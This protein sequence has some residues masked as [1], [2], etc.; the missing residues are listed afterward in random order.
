VEERK[1]Y[2]Y[3]PD[4]V[5]DYFGRTSV[6]L[7]HFHTFVGSTAVTQ[8][9]AGGH[10]HSYA[11]ETRVAQNHTHIMNGTSGIEVPV[12]MGHLHQLGGTTTVNNNHSHTYDLYTG[13]PR[14]PRNVKRQGVQATGAADKTGSG[15]TS[16]KR[17]PRFKLRFRSPSSE[18]KQ[19]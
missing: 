6:D 14:A 17:R 16:E 3:T 5:H 4:H 18:Q 9:V 7:D 12:L 19:C 2:P 13:Y 11:S 1:E 15:E 10:V 8:Y